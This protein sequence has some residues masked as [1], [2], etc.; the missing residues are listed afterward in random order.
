MT[1]AEGMEGT[2]LA[3]EG[4]SCWKKSKG[5]TVSSIQGYDRVCFSLS[6]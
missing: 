4:L 6:G 1:D 2:R 3:V 5:L